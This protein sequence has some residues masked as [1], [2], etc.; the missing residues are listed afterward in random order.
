MD[1]R[2][3]VKFDGGLGN[4][5]FDYVFYEWI[6]KEFPDKQ[7]LADL[8]LFKINMPHNGLGVWDVFPQ[9]ELK[10][11]GFKDLY[12]LTGEIPIF[13]GGPFKN[14]L[15]I[16]RKSV[17]SRLFKQSVLIYKTDDDW[18]SPDLARAAILDG[19]CYFD[20]Y[21]QD[22]EYFTQIRDRIIALFKFEVSDVVPYENDMKK[23]DAVSLHVRRGDY[24]GSVFE[25]EVN[26][27]YYRNA[28]KYVEKHVQNPHYY[29][30]SD[31]KGYVRRAFEW[32]PNKTIV[33][34]FDDEK[35]YIDMYLMS[36]TPNSIITNSTFSLWAAYLNRNENAN[37]IYPDV[38]Y[39]EHKK[40]SHWIGIKAND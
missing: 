36:L 32:L 22:S 1:N 33:D 17:N 10:N 12:E 39:L 2:I 30:F 4:Q 5:L 7:V 16:L 20:G 29:I 26:D 15:N 19:K 3:V 35:A 24:V 34:G 11:A 28:V 9:I 8:S 38:Q 37:I 40:I 21:W 13:Y 14:K 31:D 25:K 6:K 23:P 27:H 18:T